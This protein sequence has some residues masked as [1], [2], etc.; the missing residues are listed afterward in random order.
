MEPEF[1]MK[2]IIKKC[3][4]AEDEHLRRVD[5][6]MKVKAVARAR[7]KVMYGNCSRDGVQTSCTVGLLWR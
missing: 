4:G 3:I 1:A 5:L 7:A 2:E 6:L